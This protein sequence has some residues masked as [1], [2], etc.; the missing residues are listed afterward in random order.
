MDESFVEFTQHKQSALGKCAQYIA[1][2]TR[3]KK[4]FDFGYKGNERGMT[5]G[6]NKIRNTV[7]NMTNKA[8]F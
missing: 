1:T 5:F 6:G 4:Y 3:D 7:A 2:P 8:E